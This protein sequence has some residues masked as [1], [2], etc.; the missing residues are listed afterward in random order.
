MTTTAVLAFTAAGLAL[1]APESPSPQPESKPIEI[2]IC[3]DT[4]GSMNGLI[5]AAKQKLWAIVNDLA[6]AE[7]TPQLR[8]ALLTFGNDRH[9]ASDGWVKVDTPFTEDLDLVSQRLFAL[10]TDGGTELVARVLHEAGELEWHPSTDALKLVVVAGNESAEQDEE[11]QLKAVCKE[12][13]GHGIMVN[14]IFCGPETDAITSAWKDVARF[15]D[16]Q[17]ASIDQDNGTVVIETPFD[18]PLAELSASL[19]TT[20]IPYGASGARALENQR[21]QDA[22]A[23]SLNVAAAAERCTTKGSALYSCGSWD[24]VD[25]SAS[26]DFD[27]L[28][29]KSEDLPENMREMSDAE[30]QSHVESMRK[31]RA[32]IQSQVEQ[33]TRQR[34]AFVDA[35]LKQRSLD[36]SQG[37]DTAFRTA[38]RAQA[39]AKGFTFASTA[40]AEPADDGKTGS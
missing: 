36:G 15:A 40:A 29:I 31:R 21:V 32:D 22:N 33:I 39:A 11:L 10:T 26:P 1:D 5:D 35:E 8:V 38:L 14:S 13:I 2:A 18:A 20:Y 17:F 9:E 3:L 24:L 37:F 34:Q 4:S 23:A 12:L 30:R 7:P 19:N 27:L 16:G 28:A 25:A 6:L